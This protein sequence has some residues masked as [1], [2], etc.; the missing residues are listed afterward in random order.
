MGSINRMKAFFD[1]DR[2]RFVF[3]DMS[4]AWGEYAAALEEIRSW[5]VDPSVEHRQV[6]VLVPTLVE[7]ECRAPHDDVA[8][9]LRA[10]LIKRRLQ[11]LLTNGIGG[12]DEE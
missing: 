12:F 9:E 4:N 2:S 1:G 3:G 6:K 5:G 8:P 7:A 10:Q 11:R